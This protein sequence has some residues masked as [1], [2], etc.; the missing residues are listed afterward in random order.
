MLKF[1]CCVIALYITYKYFSIAIYRR[2]TKFI[3]F[4]LKAK[5]DPS[6]LSKDE[7]LE[8]NKTMKKYVAFELV[9]YIVV[10]ALFI[11]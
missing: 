6:L 11:I 3:G 1:I 9:C 8:F 10:I 4:L 7:I 2:N 5:D